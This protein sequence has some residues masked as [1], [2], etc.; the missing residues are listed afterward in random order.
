MLKEWQNIQKLTPQKPLGRKAETLQHFL[1]S[2]YKMTVSF[3]ADR[4]AT[5]VAVPT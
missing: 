5:F 3:Y 4:L 2:F 1:I